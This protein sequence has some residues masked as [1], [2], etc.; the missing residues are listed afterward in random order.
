MPAE[1]AEIGSWGEELAGE[2]LEG[3]GYKIL[4]HN[5]TPGRWGE[6]D[7]VALEK[8]TLVFVEV[9]ARSASF[10]VSPQESLT[11]HKLNVLQKMAQIYSAS[12]PEL[13]RA[14]RIDFVGVTLDE[15][16]KPRIELYKNIT[17]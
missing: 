11:P 7:I 14:L 3:R 10:R 5:W 4:E 9:R 17:V 8:D 12:H 1:A 16:R 2:Y 15:G 13:P 6:I